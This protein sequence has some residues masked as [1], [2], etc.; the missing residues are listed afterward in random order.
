MC[1][2]LCV[3]GSVSGGVP[4]S[5]HGWDLFL[6]LPGRNQPSNLPY[7]ASDMRRWQTCPVCF[8][9]GHVAAGFY[10]APG[11]AIWPST[12]TMPEQCR[13]CGGRGIVR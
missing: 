13:S 6:R 2:G 1:E 3:S 7:V 9:T 12:N 11:R 10:S 4:P 5:A 8:G